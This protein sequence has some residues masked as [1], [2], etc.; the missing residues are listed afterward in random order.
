MLL[1]VE[2]TRRQN[3]KEEEEEVKQKVFFFSLKSRCELRYVISGRVANNWQVF[4]F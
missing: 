1:T 4:Q 3:E 2:Q